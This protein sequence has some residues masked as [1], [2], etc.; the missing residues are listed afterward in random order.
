MTGRRVDLNADL[1]EG[2]G[3]YRLGDDAA[4]LAIVTSAN[5][6][7][8]FH[9][10]DPQIMAE[11]FGRAA[12]RGVTLGAHPG[13]PDLWGFGRRAL[14]FSPEEVERLVAY[15]IGAAQGMARLA[16]S[17]LRYVKP[18]GALANLAERDAAIAGAILR[19]IT[20]V[21]P[22]LA[23]LAVAHSAL[24]RQARAQEGV[25]VLSE[26]YADR[27][28]DEDGHLLSRALPGAVLHDPDAAA[29]RAVAMILDQSIPTADGRTLPT[30]IDSLCVHGDTPQSVA[31]ARAVRQALE[32]AGIML[33]AAL[34]NAAP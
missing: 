18:H 15:Q 13:F 33:R 7:C 31:M 24:E 27:G 29:E 20:A 1:G 8:G 16:G 4:M 9:A 23:V 25:T 28:Y 22:H 19:A 10:G 2:F 6:A 26:I 17:T 30:R 32:G 14:P 5:V 3:P 34:E 11:T 12:A 21:A